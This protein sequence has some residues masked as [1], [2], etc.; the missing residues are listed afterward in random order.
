M[1]KIFDVSL[2]DL[3][4][5]HKL[6]VGFGLIIAIAMLIFFSN[7]YNLAS[8]DKA[9]N[10]TKNSLYPIMKKSN[11]LTINSIKLQQWF[12]EL[13]AE[14]SMG[15]YAEGMVASQ[16]RLDAFNAIL[17]DL[18]KIDPGNE[19]ILEKIRVSF[20]RYFSTGLKMVQ[21]YATGNEEAAVDLKK[22]FNTES[23]EM[24]NL[25]EQYYTLIENTFNYGLNEIDDK[26]YQANSSGALFG[27][28][29][30]IFGMVT[31]YYIARIVARPIKN[32]TRVAFE[33]A[34]GN[35]E[36]DIQVNSDDEI[37]LLALSFK[38]LIEYM[39]ELAM[40]AESIAGNNLSVHVEPKSDKDVLGNSFNIMARN[41]K[42]MISRL[43]KNSANLVSAAFQIA[44][45]SKKMS[46]G[47][48]DQSQ[49]VN[50][51]SVAIEEMAA[52]IVQSS[53]NASDATTASR[54]ASETAGNG[55]RIV[56]ETINGMQKIAKVVS[57][58]ADSISK[59]AN[60]ADQIG[61]IISVIDDI[62]DQTNLLALNAAIEAARAGEQGRGF[63]VVADEVRK[64]A[65]RTGKATGEIAQMIKGIQSETT[66][67]VDSMQAGIMEVDK[68]RTMADQAGNSLNEIVNMSQQVMDMI[69]QIA[70][71]SEE[72]SSAAEEISKNVEH[73][74]TVT[75]DNAS[76]AEQSAT[77]AK[78]LNQ[79]AE[80]LKS[81]VSQFKL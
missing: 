23:Q 53:K 56:A 5:N 65:E 1:S 79:Q 29:A 18:K 21:A 34:E 26:I 75:K 16:E 14:R 50:H 27:L 3:K 10:K 64:L 28:L 63:A 72:Q 44:S 39:R 62:A 40:A 12:V 22:D 38:N 51:V 6:Y 59:L 37:G 41:L 68:G 17:N 11:E 54:S 32:I 8:I 33:V 42:E 80:E 74:S 45:L 67:A 55:G 7:Y 4:I 24:Q 52:T 35:L 46:E 70:T 25:I 9:V 13:A 58:S 43:N 61:D 57:G 30:L 20:D 71:A 77:A 73:I 19:Y 78:L 47:A 31:A 60:S 66:E 69:Q 81:I 76:G 49:Q 48:E 15:A 2:K 36:H